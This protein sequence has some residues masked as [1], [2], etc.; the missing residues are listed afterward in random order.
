[1]SNKQYI[2]LKDRTYYSELYDKLTI[3][4][5]QRWEDKKYSK[6]I[7][8]LKGKEKETEKIKEK[9]F[10]DVTIPLA[11]HFIKA[12]R[13]SKKSET[14]QEWMKRDKEKDEKIANAEEPQ[15]VRC[16]GC[17]SSL[18]NYIFRDLLSNYKGK[19]EVVFMFECSRC[20][21]RRAFWED[22]TEWEHKPKCAECRSEV[23]TETKRKD[24]IITH[25]YS[26]PN[27]GH[28]GTDKLDLSKK[29]KEEIDPNFEANRKKYCISEKE[30][31]EIM[32]QAEQMGKLVEK[33]K[34]KEENKEIYDAVN[35]IKK[36]KV[37]ELQN[38]LNPVIENNGYIKLE[39]EKPELQK[40]V[41]LSFSLQDNIPGR[42]KYDSVHNLQRLIRETL[43]P[44]NWRLM[45]DGITY[46][47][48][49]LQGRL[50]GIEGEENLLKLV[51]NDL[52]KAKKS[53]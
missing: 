12:E 5:C 38:L 50:K 8:K 52:E 45:S 15:D 32:F 13:A 39:F 23:K 16:L 17:S 29:V 27:C 44:T 7:T 42:E 9:L 20:G 21:K 2:H 10:H 46:R 26:C 34:D 11:L 6:D 3:E 30:G 31:F 53:R 41:T 37:A 1:M 51:E 36:L 40:D 35:K 19:E 4:K 47:L 24:N 49:F 48:G 28:V 22:G 25:I 18:I 43:A 14:I 33:F